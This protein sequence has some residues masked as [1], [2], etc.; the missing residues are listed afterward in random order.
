[1]PRSRT[2]VLRKETLTQLTSHELKGVAGGASYA[3]AF[4]LD[5]PATFETWVTCVDTLTIATC[6][7]PGVTGPTCVCPTDFG[8]A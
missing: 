2:L 7:C 5:F 3:G 1:M 8:C 4:C 6:R